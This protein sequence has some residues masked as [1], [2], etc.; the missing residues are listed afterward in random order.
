MISH[1]L[2]TSASSNSGSVSISGYDSETGNSEVVIDQS[3]S[4]SSTNVA[5][6]LALTVADLQSVFLVSDKGLTLTT[7]GT[8]TADV[9]TITISG[10]PTGGTF[11]L[12]FKGQITA[13]LAYNAAASDVQTALR[14]LSTIGA[15]NINCTGGALPGTPIVCT[16][17]GTLV[18]GTQPLLTSNIAGLTGGSPAISITHTTPGRPS[19]TIVLA[20]GIPLVW[21]V[22]SGLACPF[23]ADVTGAFVTCTPA[24]RLQGKILTS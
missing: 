4:A 1:K 23:T 13:P 22:S 11:A 8:G 3:F 14:A 10:T 19:D 12:G 5:L 16:F 24:A 21:G 18:K 20:P 6:T 7:N 9:Q 2:Q 15:S 17:A